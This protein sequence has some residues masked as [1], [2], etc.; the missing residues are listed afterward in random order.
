MYCPD[1]L[2]TPRLGE[3]SPL[4][5]GKQPQ[6]ASCLVNVAMNKTYDKC[7]TKALCVMGTKQET[8]INNLFILGRAVRP[9]NTMDHL[10]AFFVLL[11]GYFSRL[12]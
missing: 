9:D 1:G 4:I 11:T 2:L 7:K 6:R 10:R 5:W 3:K 8:K 12:H